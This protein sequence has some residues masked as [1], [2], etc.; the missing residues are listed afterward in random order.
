MRIVLSVLFLSL[1]AAPLPSAEAKRE[2]SVVSRPLDIGALQSVPTTKPREPLAPQTLRLKGAARGW[3]V[4]I[5][6]EQAPPATGATTTPGAFVR[7]P[8]NVPSPSVWRG[9]VMVGGTFHDHSLFAFDARS[10]RHLWARK[11]DDNGPSTV[12]VTDRYGFA[13]TESCTTYAITPSTG[14]VVWSR[15]LGPTVLAAPAVTGKR[16]Y[17][18]HR[19]GEH[20]QGMTALDVATGDIVWQ[21]AMTDDLIGAPVCVGDQI[22]MTLQTGALACM[23]LDGRTL[24]TA[25]GRA[26]SAPWIQ[27][28]RVFVAEEAVWRIGPPVVRCLDAGTGRT[29]WRTDPHVPKDRDDVNAPRWPA[30]NGVTQSLSGWGSDAPRPYVADGRCWVAGGRD[31]LMLD[32][33]DGTWRRRLRLPKGRRFHA[34]PVGLGKTLLFVTYEGLLIELEPR[35]GN[36]IWAVDLGGRAT[37]QPV[38]SDGFAFVA[39]E[40]LLYGIPL[41]TRSRT[42]WPQW[43]GSATRLPADK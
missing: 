3:V 9:R 32:A 33:K 34:P 39:M 14:K 4:R 29:I 26:S 43:G 22:F 2:P 17:A 35:T 36:V 30:H 1:A 37:S 10:G 21:R 12:A 8:S 11:L 6:R 16:L 18:A 13:N 23:D 41:R 38:V 40:D 27:G 42:A 20:E 15:N 28:D 25:R 24:W 19:M 7:A 31:L 5:P